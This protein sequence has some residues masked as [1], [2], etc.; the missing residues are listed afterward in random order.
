MVRDERSVAKS[1]ILHLRS[2]SFR[3]KGK[4]DVREGFVLNCNR[5]IS[6]SAISYCQNRTHSADSYSAL[7]P[8]ILGAKA[9]VKKLP[10]NGK[11]LHHVLDTFDGKFECTR[12]DER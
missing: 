11:H 1:S 2:D 10:T 12:V 3:P 9:T 5:S 4:I 7:L 6:P 8:S